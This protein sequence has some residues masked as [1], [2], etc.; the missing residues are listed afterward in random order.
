MP[1]LRTN[2]YVGQGAAWFLLVE[3]TGYIVGRH[4]AGAEVGN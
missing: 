1:K 4:A 2:M 3:I